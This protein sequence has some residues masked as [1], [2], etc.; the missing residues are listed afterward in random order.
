MFTCKRLGEPS[1]KL[2]FALLSCSAFKALI[3]E[4]LYLCSQQI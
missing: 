3:G 4:N 2:Y 1:D